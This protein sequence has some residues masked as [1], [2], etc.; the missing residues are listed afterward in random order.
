LGLGA[1]VDVSPVIVT[2][3]A[4]LIPTNGS[5]FLAKQKGTASGCFF[6][7][8]LRDESGSS[9]AAQSVS[10]SWWAQIGQRDNRRDLLGN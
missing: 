5:T 7:R 2:L 4:D 10:A 8:S 9:A 6:F 1:A 3:V